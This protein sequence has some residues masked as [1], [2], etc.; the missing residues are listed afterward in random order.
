MP[1]LKALLLFGCLT[2]LSSCV[3]HTDA[4]VSKHE[5]IMQD[6]T[7]HISSVM[8]NDGNRVEFANP[9]GTYSP[10]ARNVTGTSV[11]GTSIILPTDALTSCEVWRGNFWWSA[12]LWF[13][14]LAGLLTFMFHN[15]AGSS[16]E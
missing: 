5:L 1:K 6:S 13:G 2:L 3:I 7:D 14:L 4:L 15:A 10:N 8:M 12:L 16:W 9:G 11:K